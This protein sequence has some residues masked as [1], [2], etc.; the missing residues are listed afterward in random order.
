MEY[1][2]P[3]EEGMVVLDAL[4]WVQAHLAPG[5]DP[6]REGLRR[7]PG[8]DDEHEPRIHPAGAGRC[9]CPPEDEPRSH[10]KDELRRE[11]QQ[12]ELTADVRKLQPEEQGERCDRQEQHGP[13]DVRDLGSG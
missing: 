5:L 11:Q 1:R 2:V 10:G 4:H 13:G 9:E 12:E 6:V 3:T 8:S 7:W